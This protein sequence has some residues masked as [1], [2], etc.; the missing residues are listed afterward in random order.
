[1]VTLTTPSSIEPIEAR[2]RLVGI[3]LDDIIQSDR[4]L[5]PFDAAAIRTAHASGVKVVLMSARSPEAIHRFWAL[6]GLGTPVIALNGA[7]VFDYPLHRVLF[8]QALT[9]EHLQ[10]I[11]Q[12]V[13]RLMPKAAVGLELGGSWVVNRLDR[14]A[15]WQIAQ[16]KTWPAA[17]GSLRPYLD[18]P[19]YQ[20][21]IDGDA[22]DLSQL[23]PHLTDPAV[24]IR[25]YADPDRLLICSAG[26][27]RSWA[28]MSLAAD[29]N[30]ALHQIMVI[31]GG[32]QD[33][34]ALPA[35]AF[36]LSTTEQQEQGGSLAGLSSS[37]TVARGVAEALE[38]YIVP[39]TDLVWT[40]PP[41]SHTGEED[42]WLA[43]EL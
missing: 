22:T 23:A 35:A 7:L 29:F 10:R 8:G 43:T 19:V 27:S 30:V 4:S 16:T 40:E 24:S 15:Q 17:V 26:A 36:T 25:H 39:I 1:M 41:A 5:H 42:E 33:R 28:L 20:L 9:P 38:Q 37:I 18:A 2:I 11:L 13:Q 12:T 32:G 3:D 31:S 14:V 34:A 6:L 21:W